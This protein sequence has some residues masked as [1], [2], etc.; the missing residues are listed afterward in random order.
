MSR[1]TI[2][3][4]LANLIAFLILFSVLCFVV[5]LWYG[6]IMPILWWLILPFFLLQVIRAKASNA[7]AFTLLHIVLG[8]IVWF[9]L[10]NWFAMG[11][12]MAATVY[13]YV[14]KGGGEWEPT[15]KTGITA[16]LAHVVMFFMAQ[17]WHDYAEPFQ[18][19]LAGTC[20]VVLGLIIIYIH[21]ENIDISLRM[22]QHPANER[23]SSRRLLRTNN[24]L[25]MVFTVGVVLAGI[26][27]AALPLGRMLAAGW[28]A[29]RGGL[30]SFF[31]LFERERPPLDSF[32]FTPVERVMVIEADRFI[33]LNPESIYLED[34]PDVV[35][36]DDINQVVPVDQYLMW[37]FLIIG[38]AIVVY[39]FVR[40]FV[41]VSRRKNMSKSNMDETMSL[42]RDL[43]GDIRD[44]LPR[45]GRYS[46]NAIRRAYA[47][48]VNWHIR[49][50]AA[51]RRSDTTDTIANKIR[52]KENIDEL[53]AMYERVR[54]FK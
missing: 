36:I 40:Y 50:G 29:V 26:V 44:L 35:D 4:I 43:M 32:E 52:A 54:Y 33:F 19:Q 22:L 2:K 23:H 47:K 38:L 46:K 24:I 39:N 28:G 20:I 6:D 9:L 37:G 53:T 7:F 25:I 21:M 51:V 18:Q 12:M 14:V 49:R 30:S 48:K 8:A 27:V 42:K 16:L 5:F 17:R 10:N 15:R 45:F 13:S 41:N 34:L 3:H 31:A 1:V 11:F